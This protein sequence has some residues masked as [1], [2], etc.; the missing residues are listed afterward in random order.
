MVLETSNDFFELMNSKFIM[1]KTMV[2]I[3]LYNAKGELKRKK[4]EGE[5]WSDDHHIP[6]R[7]MIINKVAEQHVAVLRKELEAADPE[8]KVTN[9]RELIK[10]NEVLHFDVEVLDPYDEVKYLGVWVQPTMFTTRAADEA[11]RQAEEVAGALAA[12]SIESWG[13]TPVVR[14]TGG[15]RVCYSLKC[16]AVMPDMMPRLD[17]RMREMHKHKHGHCG[18]Y[19]NDALDAAH[20]NSLNWRIRR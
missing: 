4:R 11:T 15:Q 8:H 18:P 12:T 19:P 7:V 9:K 3:L 17:T 10:L 2:E 13:A 16:I 14:C 1:S 5:Q 20:N 6:S